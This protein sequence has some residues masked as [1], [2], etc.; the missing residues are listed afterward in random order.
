MRTARTIAEVREVLGPQR[1]AQATIGLVATMGALHEGHRSLLAAARKDCDIVVMSLFVNPTQF[2]AGEDFGG[3]PR[4]EGADAAL[5]EQSGVDL[6]FAPAVEEMYAE[7]AATSVV[8]RGITEPL[9]GAHRGAGHFEGVATVV[10]KLLNIVAPDVAYFG[11]KDAQ[12]VLVIERLV[13]DL[14]VPTRIVVCPTLR[15]PDGLAMS[16]RNAYLTPEQRLRAPALSAALDRAASVIGAGERDA[17]VAVAVAQRALHEHD[18]D[19]EYFAIV[20]PVTLEPVD[21]IDRP[22]LVAVAATVGRARL[23]DNVLATPAT[24]ATE[25]R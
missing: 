8:V 22:V 2:G 19:A 17:T 12:Q 1:R 15:E 25:S 16:S 10:T 14:A 7:D 23:I 5:A 13:R 21:R 3:Y 18:I 24:N 4:D 20:D 11:Q 6:L 9:E